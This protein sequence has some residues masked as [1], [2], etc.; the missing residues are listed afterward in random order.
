MTRSLLF[1]FLFALAAAGCASRASGPTPAALGPAAALPDTA[2]VLPTTAVAPGGAVYAA[3]TRP[4]ADGADVYLARLDGH[5]DA[6]APPVR[7]TTRPAAAV[8]AQAPAQVAAGPDGRVVVVWAEQTRIDGRRFPASELWAAYSNDGGRTVSAPRRVHPDAGF[9]TSRQF[10]AVAVGPDGT[11]YVAW[12]DGQARDAARRAA[13]ASEAHAGHGH[14]GDGLPGTQLLVARSTDGGRT[15]EPATV[16]ARNTCQCCRTALAVADDGTVYVAWRHLFDGGAVRDMAVARSD[17][18]GRTFGM[19]VRVHEDGWALDGCPHAGP[20][21]AVDADGGL[22]VLWYTGVDGGAGVY[23]A[24]SRDR[25]AAFTPAAALARD[26]PVA[27]VS[28]ARDGAG[29]TWIAWEHPRERRVYVLP[30]G[31]D[32]GVDPARAV[33]YAGAQP[34]LASAG[35][36]MALAWHDGARAVLARSTP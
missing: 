24:H 1:C 35:G 12:L 9:P 16:V 17:D 4:G 34:A 31:P 15:F 20:A 7:V 29:G 13:A 36:A 10:H 33:P 28:A 6:A 18:G 26:V 21:L 3:W 2:A 23:Y 30:V 5:P 32:G 27:Q 25:G 14:G 19:P 11:L 8:H 22:H